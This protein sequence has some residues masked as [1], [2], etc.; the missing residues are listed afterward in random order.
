MNDLI[1]WTRR[2]SI[3]IFRWAIG[4]VFLWF[5]LLKFLPQPGE[6]EMLAYRTIGWISNHT[7][8]PAAAL[9]ILG[10]VETL[11]GLGLLLRLAMPLVLLLLFVIL[12]GTLLPLIIFPQ[13]CWDGWFKPSLSGHYI[14]KNLVFIAGGFVL[15]ATV[16]RSRE[17]AGKEEAHIVKQ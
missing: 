6:A 11:T 12:G 14:I 1:A 9:I 10:I 4:L 3:V 17:R 13:Q 16:D 5:G 2:Y 15:T 8:S 7:I